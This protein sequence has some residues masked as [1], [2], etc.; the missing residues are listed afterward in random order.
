MPLFELRQYTAQPGK[1]DQ[2]V[3]FMEGVI[4]PY[5]VSKGMTVVASFVGEEDEDAFV[6]IR[7]FDD[8]VQRKEL[9]EAVYESDYWKTEVAPK[10][11]EFNQREKA[12]VT[13]LL[14]TAT[15]NLQ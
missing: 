10:V 14:P 2:L 1:R 15:S 4:I 6:W 9:Y 13:R 8:E 7:R 5:Q 3:E 12:V 11:P